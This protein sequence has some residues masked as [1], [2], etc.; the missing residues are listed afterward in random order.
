MYGSNSTLPDF[1]PEHQQALALLSEPLNLEDTFT[2]DDLQRLAQAAMPMQTHV[3]IPSRQNPTR[4]EA[5][6]PR[7]PRP[8]T[9]VTVA[10]LGQGLV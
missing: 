9:T 3:F 1:G 4:L 6:S 10:R 7:N 5:Q 8:L 2:S